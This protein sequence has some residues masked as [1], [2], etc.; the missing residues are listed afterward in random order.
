MQIDREKCI[1][2]NKCVP[3]CVMGAI[4]PATN[5]SAPRR[6]ATVVEDECVDCGACVR[7]RVCPTQALFRPHYGWPR[8]VRMTFSDPLVEHR[9]TRVLGRGTEEVKTNDVTGRVRRGFFGIGVEVGRPGLGARFSDIEKITMKVAEVGASFEP[10]N[11]VTTLMQDRSRGKLR[12]DILGERVLSAIVEFTIPEGNLPSCI[13]KLNEVSFEIETVF[14][15]TLISRLT[16][17][18][19]ITTTP[20]LEA[21]G[22]NA[23]PNG[24]TNVGLGRP[25]YE[26]E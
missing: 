12:D 17:E 7:A 16:E 23:Y 10:K 20:L 21:M 6:I 25:R 26:E 3:Y 15:V 11:P 9:E 14:S 13:R 24:K 2:C 5:K 22:I 8:S 1:G 4:E 18:G 19:K